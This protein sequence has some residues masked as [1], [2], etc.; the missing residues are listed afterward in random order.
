MDGFESK[1]DTIFTGTG[2]EAFLAVADDDRN[3]FTGPVI[4]L[5]EPPEDLDFFTRSSH[6]QQRMDCPVFCAAAAAA[7]DGLTSFL[8]SSSFCAA[9]VFCAAAAAAEDGN[10]LFFT[11]AAD[12]D[13]FT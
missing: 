13:F 11:S 3:F 4:F 9:A 12:G 2:A 8:C 10:L 6:Q 1:G 5:A 7:E